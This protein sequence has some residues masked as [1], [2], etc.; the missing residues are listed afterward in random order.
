MSSGPPSEPGQATLSR[1]A[2]IGRYVILGLVGRGGMGEVYAAY[3][4]E[5][6]RKVAVKLVRVKPGAGVT[7]TEG[8]QRTLREAQAIARL[9]HPNV[10]VVYDVGTFRDQV[11]IAMEFVEGNTVTYWVESQPRSW[12]EVLKVF[13]A[14]GRG[15][16]AAHDKGLVHRDFKPD[17]VMVGK[18]GEVR[19]MDFGLARQV[20]GSGEPDSDPGVPIRSNA[21]ADAAEA[22][23]GPHAADP[24]STMV[25]NQP[26]GAAAAETS[27]GPTMLDARLTRTGAMMG[28][29]AYMAP[30][31]FLGTGTDARTD[32]FSFCIALYEALY[33]ER[34]FRGNTMFTLT[35]AVVQGD[36]RDA[37]ANTKVPFW[38]RKVLLRGL[39]PKASERWSSM[40]ELL[41][42]LGKNPSAQRRKWLT[43]TAIP[44]LPIALAFGIGKTIAS[45]EPPCSGG[46][47][48]LEGIWELQGPGEPETLRK[49]QIRRAFMAT[50]K[51]YAADVYAT[52]SKAL[53]TYAR[54]WVQMH[55]ETCEATEIQREQSSE[56]MDLRMTCLQERLGGLRA[57]SNVFS[58][59][60]GEV[61]ENSVSAANSLGSLD[62][63]ADVP[64]LRALVKPPDDAATRSRVADLRNRLAE[65][66]A[67]FDAG[68]WRRAREG[69]PELIAEARSTGYKPLLA[70]TLLRMGTM[71]QRANATREAEETFM[72]AYLAA[73]G[74]R[75]DE[76][77]AEAARGLLW[78]VGYLGGRHAEGQH[79]AKL[80]DAILQRL[81][82]HDLMQAWLVNDLGGLLGLMGKKQEMLTAEKD[83]LRLKE[84]ALG[85]NHPDVGFSEGNIAYSLFELGKSQEAL[86]HIDRAVEIV[87]KGLGTSHPDY[88]I[89]LSNRGEILNALGRFEEARQSFETAIVTLEREVGV[90]DR[91][92]AYAL[93]GIGIG[94]LAL[95][96]PIEA[97]APLERALK[98][99]DTDSDATKRAET[100][101]ALARALWDSGR[102]RA[103]ARALAEGAREG[104]S[105]TS[106]PAK[107]AE[108]EEWL[109]NHRSKV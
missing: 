103:R 24:M 33:G 56:V 36:I 68:Q 54:N 78:V 72:Q 96:N 57:L 60:T 105:E 30:E 27:S 102:A 8:R 86:Q 35:S 14:A 84:K 49:I 44:M 64:V 52:V 3:D 28:T 83:A 5:L 13:M 41:E 39:R 9:S 100:K 106:E 43:I 1:G 77:R 37:P 85:S 108:V 95:G 38:V 91:N 87:R 18:N 76:V 26:A 90:D 2:T 92:L 94:W 80:A 109:A 98:I 51:G 19:V 81:G 22:L 88:A 47:A 34:P 4:P 50:G 101:F 79:W 62:H 61:V 12:Q 23:S 45:R 31:Q 107:K 17:N 99:R 82:G 59:A 71:L 32:Q 48:K 55:R 46:P 6:D 42:A 53:T 11:F 65:R 67:M 63:C 29:P 21:A 58:E 66:K 7:V 20:N 70:E 97:I 25:L 40:L 69:M 93:T 15:L 16:A 10:V 74:S 73:E 89:V 104:L 75:H